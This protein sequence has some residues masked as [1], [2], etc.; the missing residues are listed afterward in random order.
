MMKGFDLLPS[1]LAAVTV[2]PGLAFA[3]ANRVCESV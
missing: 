1:G 2:I 3:F